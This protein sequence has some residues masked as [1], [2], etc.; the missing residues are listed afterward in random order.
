MTTSF[1]LS[2]SLSFQLYHPTHTRDRDY[3]QYISFYNT[4]Y[5][6]LTILLYIYKAY[7]FE[8]FRFSF[9]FLKELGRMLS[10]RLIRML[11]QY[12]DTN[13]RRWKKKGSCCCC[14]RRM[15][16]KEGCLSLCVCTCVAFFGTAFRLLSC[17][18]PFWISFRS[19]SIVW[20]RTR[21]YTLLR[22]WRLITKNELKFWNT[23]TASSDATA[24]TT[25]MMRQIQT[26]KNVSHTRMKR[27]EIW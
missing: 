6:L 8:S 27:A 2:L 3:I 19:S 13:G 9:S 15:N 16:P 7:E 21:F 23:S 25:N 12:S 10:A 22:D 4:Y 20:N 11:Y 5:T 24:T 26:T 14:W 18:I 1:S 17:A